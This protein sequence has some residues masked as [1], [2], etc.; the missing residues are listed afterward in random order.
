MDTI[1]ASVVVPIAAIFKGHAWLAAL[2]LLVGMVLFWLWKLSQDK[3]VLDLV[4]KFGA[5]HGASLTTIKE[6]IDGLRDEQGKLVSKVQELELKV[7]TLGCASAPNCA[8]RVKG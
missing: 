5:D 2:L 3:Q 7:D 6:S 1:N 8:Q 4:G